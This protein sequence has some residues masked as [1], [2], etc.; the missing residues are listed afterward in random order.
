MTQAKQIK[1]T[2]LLTQ[3]QKQFIQN[4]QTLRLAFKEYMQ[5]REQA[6]NGLIGNAYHA[7]ERLRLIYRIIRN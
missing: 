7:R 2:K 5:A 6:K 4:N 3:E 1:P